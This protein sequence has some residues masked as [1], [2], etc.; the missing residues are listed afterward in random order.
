MAQA[1]G[2][3]IY[4]PFIVLHPSLSE[5]MWFSKRERLFNLAFPTV[6]VDFANLCQN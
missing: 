2:S 1:F 5:N 6:V 4:I 3:V